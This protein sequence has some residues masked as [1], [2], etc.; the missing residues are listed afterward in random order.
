ME[1]LHA[2]PTEEHADFCNNPDTVVQDKEVA[3]RRRERVDSL[4]RSGQGLSALLSL[5]SELKRN[6]ERHNCV[7]LAVLGTVIKIMHA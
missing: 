1:H 6:E 3:G 5:D 4:S 2:S 7:T